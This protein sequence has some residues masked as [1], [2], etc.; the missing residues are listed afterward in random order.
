MLR[1]LWLFTVFL[2]AGRSFEVLLNVYPFTWVTTSVMVLT[3]Y[4][5]IR[6][7]E[8]QRP[9]LKEREELAEEAAGT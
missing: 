3:A 2:W 9:S 8:F 4:F 1:V 5:V 7:R 6:R